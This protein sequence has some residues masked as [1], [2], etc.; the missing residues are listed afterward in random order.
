MIN[1]PDLNSYMPMLNELDM[2]SLMVQVGVD[3]AELEAAAEQIRVE[4]N[5]ALKSLVGE[6]EANFNEDARH[7]KT[8]E[9]EWL[10]AE[11]LW[12]GTSTYERRNFGP[13]DRPYSG[14]TNKT[15]SRRGDRRTPGFNIVR[16]KLRIAK[17]QLEMMQFGSG[18]DKNFEITNIP[19]SDIVDDQG[20]FTPVTGPNG[21][22][23]TISEIA[24]KVISE[25]DERA[26]RMDEEIWKCLQNCNYGEKIRAGFDD[27]LTYGTVIYYGP[28]NSQ[29][30]NKRR[31]K[32]QT[33]DG[34]TI[35]VTQK[36]EEVKPDFERI[37]PWLF[38]PDYRALK[39]D[40][41]E[42]ATVV[43]ICTP[44][45]L[46]EMSKQEGFFK[47]EILEL[48][49]DEPKSDYYE[50]FH[51]RAS[52]YDNSNYLQGKYIVLRYHGHLG[53]KTLEQIGVNPPF[54][55]PFDVYPCVI[56]AC[57]GKVLSVSLETLESEDRL[58]FAVSTWEADP[59]SLFGFGAILLYDAQRVVNKTYKM[60]LDNAGLCAMPQA[61]INQEMIK[62]TDGQPVIE[63]GK[64]WNMTE[65]GQDIA[66]AIQFF[67]VPD[68]LDMLTKVLNM[69]REYG[70]E[71]SLIPL[72]SAG[73]GDSTMGD[74]GA[75][76][77]SL[78][79]KASTTVLSSK[80]REHDDDITKPI[81][82]WYYEWL[83]QFSDREDIKGDF[84]I[85]VKTSTAY[86]SKAMEQRDLERLCMEYTQSDELKDLLNGDELYRARLAGMRLPYDRIVRD[87]A[88]VDKIRAD[89]A[90]EAEQARQTD[91][92]FM[93]AQSK[94][95]TAQARQA[96]VEVK[97]QQ[98]E[99]DAN[100]G[101]QEAQ[102]DHQEKMANYTVTRPAESQARVQ[103]AQLQAQTEMQKLQAQN[104][105]KEA[106]IQ[107]N[108]HVHDQKV[109]QQNFQH[110]MKQVN[111]QQKLKIEDRNSK[112]NE[113]KVLSEHHLQRK[114]I[115]QDGII[116][117]T[118]KPKQP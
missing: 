96:D 102:M 113:F 30:A 47:D 58:P 107:A 2:S 10:E 101:L 46:R 64:I 37:N 18:S 55:D 78:E 51:S 48:L 114:K 25:D 116:A 115:I 73:L 22:T 17:A 95:L 72:I 82:R 99:F 44:R 45:D 19:A 15:E 40:E 112:I 7:R 21:E 6:I 36:S 117:T 31:Q 14:S 108:I 35:W 50:F 34:K 24:S 71:E 63:P 4:R 103:V 9:Q 49:K 91:P 75:T 43:K 56:Y 42:R 5:N 62:N 98:L 23:T 106:H 68:N 39:I 16:P 79:M 97:K 13:V 57:Q 1:S 69:A 59:S 80:A 32:L 84:D 41:A 118:N 33:S 38:F 52:L 100:T 89:R 83:M 60:V 109:Q 74:A 66:K 77:A 67:Y 90:K 87:Q 86:L 53:M 20:N 3:P 65:Y 12:L 70:N 61:A 104:A 11:R 111:E 28:F 8:K 29:K 93:D 81:V 54:E 76:G 26:R 27:K 94:L 88:S 92:I 110:G 105:Q 85:D